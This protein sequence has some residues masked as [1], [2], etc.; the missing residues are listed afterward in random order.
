PELLTATLY[1]QN[2]PQKAEEWLKKAVAAHAKD[3]RATRA[4]AGWLLD[5]GQTDA[6]QPYLD[7]AVKLDPNNQETIA[8]Q[9]LMARYR[10]DLPAAE[11]VFEGLYR[12][13]PNYAFAAWNLALVLADSGDK[14]KQRRAVELAEAEVRKNPRA[15]EAYAVLGWCYYK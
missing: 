8:L 2:E 14:E 15:P 7:A 4:Y 12:N 9:G 13:H 11:R 10:K 5:S 3:A 1:G 6:A